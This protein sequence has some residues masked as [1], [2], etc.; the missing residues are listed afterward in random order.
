MSVIESL[1]WQQTLR[2]SCQS[3]D[4]PLY[5]FP[6]NESLIDEKGDE[7]GQSTEQNRY[8]KRFKRERSAF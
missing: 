3:F 1:D 4:I 2:K 6:A 7:Q 8:A 5:L